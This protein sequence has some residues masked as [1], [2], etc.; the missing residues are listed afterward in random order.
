MFLQKKESRFRFQLARGILV[1]ALVCSCLGFHTTGMAAEPSVK[2]EADQEEPTVFAAA[3]K[4]LD[5]E[6]VRDLSAVYAC[7]APSSVYC[8]TH[9][10]EAFVAEANASP[11]R[12]IDR[13]SVV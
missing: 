1:A 4:Y 8:A 9:D 10:Y 11:V 12:I 7:L 6:V 2:T 13:K 5:A 3:K